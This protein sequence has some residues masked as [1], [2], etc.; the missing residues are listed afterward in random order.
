MTAHQND[1]CTEMR[2]VR[3]L[4]RPKLPGPPGSDSLVLVGLLGIVLGTLLSRLEDIV[5]RADKKLKNDVQG[6]KK[7][8]IEITD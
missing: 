6:F 3:V 5:D 1:T 2:T 8:L 7:N 4:C